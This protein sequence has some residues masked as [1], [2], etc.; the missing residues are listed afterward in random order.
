MTSFGHPSKSTPR[1]RTG[2]IRLGCVFTLWLLASV[3]PCHAE[4]LTGRDI[5]QRVYD[6]DV[7]RDSLA[8]AEMILVSSGGHERARRLRAYTKTDGPVRKVLI[9][10]LSPADIEGTGFLAIEKEGGETEQFL[11]LPDLKRA[12]RIVASQKS[13]SFVNSD[14]TYEDMERRPVDDAEHRLAGEETIANLPCWILESRPLEKAESQY[15]L[16]RTWV[17]KDLDVPLRTHYF[18]KKGRHFKT[19]EVRGLKQIEGLWT[20]MDVLMHNLE[21]DHRTILKTI[22]IDYN[23]GLED[24]AFTV[25]ALEAW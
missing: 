23:T 12:R 24:T 19:Y 20:E 25:R 5:A 18:D 16:L 8:E 1:T 7:G 13:R 17:A 3:F 11:F 10:F 4:D 9:R 15:G 22:S 6:R 21:D 2:L 14:F